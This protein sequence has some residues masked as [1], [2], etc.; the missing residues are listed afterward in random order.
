VTGAKATSGER[1]PSQ[2]AKTSKNL[3]FS[4]T[5]FHNLILTL[6]SILSL[7]HRGGE[8]EQKQSLDHII[9]L[10]SLKIC[11]TILVSMRGNVH[12]KYMRTA[13]KLICDN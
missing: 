3:K 8:G 9:C 4:S 13:L 5:F 11:S 7:E 1:H 2:M 6:W 12:Y 10:V